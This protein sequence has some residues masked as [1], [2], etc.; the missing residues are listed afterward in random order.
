MASY[1]GLDALYAHGVI[2]HAVKYVDQNVHVNGMEN[3]W[4][5]LKRAGD[6]VS[7]RAPVCLASLA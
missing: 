7:G 6:P 3:F 5:L 2:N 4:S 1:Q